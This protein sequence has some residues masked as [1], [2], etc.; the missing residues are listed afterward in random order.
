MVLD[1]GRIVEFDT[2]S[3]LL[4]DTSSRFYGLCKAN[5]KEEFAVLKEMAEARADES[6]PDVLVVP[7][8]V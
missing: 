3:S 1:Q 7:P 2:P 4:Q 6:V 8:S 5:G